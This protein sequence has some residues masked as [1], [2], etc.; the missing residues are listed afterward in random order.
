MAVS[1]LVRHCLSGHTMFA[2]PVQLGESGERG[3]K[4]QQRKQVPHGQD[5]EAR[6]ED[7][8]LEG[9]HTNQHGQAQK[10]ES[11]GRGDGTAEWGNEEEEGGEPQKGENFVAADL[12]GAE[13]EEPDQRHE[14]AHHTPPQVAWEVEGC[15]AGW[16]RGGGGEVRW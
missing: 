15:G 3:G 11:E 16:G 13:R 9:G 4:N 10:E 14:L 7:R 12:H 8:D 2:I 1:N 6:E 5:K